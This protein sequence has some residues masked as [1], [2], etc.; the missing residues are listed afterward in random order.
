MQSNEDLSP[1]A[2]AQFGNHNSVVVDTL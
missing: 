2:A 1:R